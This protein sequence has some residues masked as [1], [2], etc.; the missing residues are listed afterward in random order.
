MGSETKS[1]RHLLGFVG[2][3]AH[4]SRRP[5]H[6]HVT[7]T[8]DLEAIA[9]AAPRGVSHAV[10]VHEVVEAWGID[11]NGT[12][13]TEK[14]DTDKGSHPCAATVEKACVEE[15]AD[16]HLMRLPGLVEFLIGND[17]KGN[18]YTTVLVYDRGG[19][20][21]KGRCEQLFPSVSEQ[22]FQWK[23]DGG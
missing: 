4:E 13:F 11:V 23:E 22:K 16:S 8:S 5:V 2:I 12:P 1:I 3:P 9:S 15:A 17:R 20:R 21:K 19:P 14:K 10:L 7:I 6:H 18:V